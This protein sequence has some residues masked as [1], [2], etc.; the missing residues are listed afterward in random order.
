MLIELHDKKM[1]DLRQVFWQL[2]CH[3]ITKSVTD[4]EVGVPGPANRIRSLEI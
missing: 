4:T 2:S 1:E 3:V